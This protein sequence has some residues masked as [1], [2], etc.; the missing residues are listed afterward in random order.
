[1]MIIQFM[2][3]VMIVISFLYVLSQRVRSRSIFFPIIV[4]IVSAMFLVWNPDTANKIANFVGV[5]RGADLI[6]YFFMILSF[7]VGFN[8]HIKHKRNLQHITDLAR[9]VT[10]LRVRSPGRSSDLSPPGHD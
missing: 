1:M 9:E 10:L 5:G 6:I 8:L 4:G 7:F 2:L 3:T